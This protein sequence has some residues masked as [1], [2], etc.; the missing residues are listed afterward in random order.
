MSGVAILC[1]LCRLALDREPKTWHCANGHSFDVARE[2]YVNLLPVQ[3]KNSLEPGD[4]PQM[5][6]ARR[7]FL[8]A[9]HYRP[10]LD[11]VL[12]VLAPLSPRSLLD[13]GC[14][15]GSYTG[16]FG[17]VAGQVIGLDIAKPAIRLAARRFPGHLWIVGSGTQIPVGTGDV[18]AVCNLFA[19]LHVGE[20]ARV[21]KPEGHLLVVTQA[22]D[23][24]WSL[25]EQLFDEVRPHD[26]DKFLAALDAAFELQARREVR[27]ALDLA[28]S[29]LRRLLQMTPYAWK[30]RP[31]RR[32]ALET[33]DAFATQASFTLMLFR[34]RAETV[35]DAESVAEAA[36]AV[37]EIAV[38]EPVTEVRD[39]PESPE[40][41]EPSN[42]WTR[43]KKKKWPAAS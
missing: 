20:L 31:E 24:L 33:R 1:P 43:A 38:P 5:V 29:D 4:D 39:S 27:F 40:M 42:P 22:P 19:Q 8:Q 17:A 10:L 28:Q 11:A 2:G 3:H 15:E 14:G 13:V 7:E 36:A 12:E 9:G 23:H 34:R 37:D 6:T 26:P 41:P 30:A 16:A 21:L 32:A 35:V 25:R 18:D